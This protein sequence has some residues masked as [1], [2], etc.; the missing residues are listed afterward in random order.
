MSAN[1][2]YSVTETKRGSLGS[3]N[4]SMYTAVSITNFVKEDIAIIYRDG[5]YA[6]LPTVPYNCVYE[7]VVANVISFVGPTAVQHGGPVNSLPCKEITISRNLLE[8]NG[9]GV[10]VKELD[11][12]VAFAR[13]AN[14]CKHPKAIDYEQQVTEAKDALRSQIENGTF[15]L[16][17]NDPSKTLTRVYTE[18]CGKIL[19]IY[20]TNQ[21]TIDDDTT[22]KILYND[23]GEIIS[24]TVIVNEILKDDMAYI[25]NA[26]ITFLAK[27]PEKAAEIAKASRFYTP[28][29]FDA[30]AKRFKEEADKRIAIAKTDAELKIQR[31]RE[32]VQTELDEYEKLKLEYDRLKAVHDAYVAEVQGATEARKTKIESDNA[33]VKEREVE[34]KREKTEADRRM[35]DND[36]RMSEAKTSSAVKEDTFK[37]WVLIA[38]A[39]C[40]AL[41]IIAWKIFDRQT[42]QKVGWSYRPPPASE[43]GLRALRNLPRYSNLTNPGDGIYESYKTVAVEK[44]SSY[45]K[46]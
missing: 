27:T 23:S 11:F 15:T 8:E 43:L 40:P 16:L 36:V 24:K 30:E 12:V 44:V 26:P 5:S 32:K 22:L 2:T 31:E 9:G 37:T 1:V 34:V 28:A 14:V 42:S 17:V 19:E 46:R 4:P 21:A 20:V 3:P 25:D 6:V 7:H 18:L 38:G 45:L 41:A 39:V 33:D 35:S 13:N 29:H 10:Y